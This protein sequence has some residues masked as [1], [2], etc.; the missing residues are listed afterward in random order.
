MADGRSPQLPRPAGGRRTRV[1]PLSPGQMPGRRLPTGAL[2]RPLTLSRTR[3]Q[4]PDGVRLGAAP[5]RTK[6]ATK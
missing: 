1:P 3:G 5:P 4:V 6:A 2:G